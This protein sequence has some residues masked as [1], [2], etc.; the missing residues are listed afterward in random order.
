MRSS[1][2]INIGQSTRAYTAAL[3]DVCLPLPFVG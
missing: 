2:H 3:A 1:W